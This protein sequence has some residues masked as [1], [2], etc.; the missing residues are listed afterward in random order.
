[1]NILALLA[2]YSLTLNIDSLVVTAQRIREHTPVALCRIDAPE[3][4]R[5]SVGATS[6]PQQL[7]L[8]PS[9]VSVSECGTG[10]GYTSFSVRG[11]SGAHTAVSLNGISLADAES[12]QV[13]WVNIP[14]LDNILSSLQLQRGLGTATCGPGAFGATLDM[15]T[16]EQ[17]DFGASFSAG[18]GSFG[19]WKGGVRFSGGEGQKGYFLDLSLNREHT[20]GYIRNAPADVGSVYLSAGR[21]MRKDFV[22]LL[23]LLGKQKSAITWNGVPFDVYPEDPRFNV[24]EGDTDNFTQSHLQAHWAHDFSPALRWKNSADWTRGQGWYEIGG[25]SDFLAN[26]LLAA[27]SDLQWS[28]PDGVMTAVAYISD[29]NGAHYGRHPSES[30]CED[31]RY[32]ARKSEADLSLRAE[33]EPL[34]SLTLFGEL[35]YRGV[36]YALFEGEE[37]K[38]WNFLNPRLGLNYSPSGSHKLYCFAALGHREPARS[39]FEAAAD[40][41]H[42][43]MW[44]FETGYK[45]FSAFLAA[46]VNLYHMGYS[47]MLLETGELDSQG[48]PVKKNVPR[49]FRSGIEAALKVNPCSWITLAGNLTLSVNRIGGTLTP[50]LLSPGCIAALTADLKP[51]EGLDIRWSSKFVGRQHYDNTGSD[52]SLIP[53]YSVSSLSAEQS[54]VPGGKWPLVKLGARI[55]NVFNRRYYAYACS[56][57]VYPGAPLNFSVRLSLEF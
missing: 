37:A 46:S 33:I 8:E 34:K 5:A 47:D 55:D 32:S 54:F 29:Y 35:Q 23:W 38:V 11:V 19:T 31:Y 12:Q 42:E 16:T 14:S 22:Q 26:D 15:S 25:G 24:S 20:D 51:S 2:A 6:L 21:R 41:R 43:R 50:L 13:F 1:M 45:F 18:Y 17:K 53:A 40:A 27:R 52:A 4:E 30:D 56:S 36:R 28:I 48:Y 44:N 49:A 9:V 3:L 10:V 7:A 39:D 57:G